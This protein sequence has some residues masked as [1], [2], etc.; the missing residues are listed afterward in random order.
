MTAAKTHLIDVALIYRKNLAD[1][2][3]DRI[4]IP[5]IAIGDTTQ[6]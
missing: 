2:R 6:F 1:P 4:H 3:G 5:N